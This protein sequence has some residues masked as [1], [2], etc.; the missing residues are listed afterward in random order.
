MK[1][2]IADDDLVTRRLL[3]ANLHR[4]GHETISAADGEEAWTLVQL[5]KAEIGVALL[6]R[7]M[8]GLDGIELCRRIRST[9][10]GG[11]IYVLI[12]TAH[13]AL[14]DIVDGL[15][16]G[17]DD[18]TAKPFHPAE[19]RLRI[20]VGL[21]IVNLERA[22]VQANEKLRTQAMTDSLTGLLN[23]GAAIGRLDE[24]LARAA[25]DRL[26]LTILMIDVDKFKQVNDTYGHAA[27]DQMAAAVAARIRAACRSYDVVGRYGG[28]E[29]LA[30]LP[31]A[32]A[33][34][35]SAIARRLQDGL[36][37]SPPQFEGRT[38]PLTLSIGVAAVEAHDS[39]ATASAALLRA[40]D[41]A[42]YQAKADGRDRITV[43]SGL[44]P[45]AS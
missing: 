43:A 33:A 9:E 15:N 27:G 6:D 25:R 26:P 2:L 13:D 1:I 35:G 29:F 20:Q 5:H 34:A 21:R 39:A 37:Q 30:I 16:A 10:L 7:S 44:A 17:A 42:L 40:S 41:Q 45:S 38:I 18:Y 12:L 3:E 24:E 23:H 28:D 19:L 11:Y 14:A 8:P 36:R 31:N 4:W 32:D 22:M